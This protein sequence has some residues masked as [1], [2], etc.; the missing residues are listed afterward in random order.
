[1]FVRV[2]KAGPEQTAE[3]GLG[4]RGHALEQD[5]GWKSHILTALKAMALFT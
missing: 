5:Q 1:M 3:W 4:A 2:C